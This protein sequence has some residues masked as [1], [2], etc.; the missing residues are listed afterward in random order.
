MALAAAMHGMSL[1]ANEAGATN[2]G[3]P[4]T[5]LS[6][7]IH[8]ANNNLAA[9]THYAAPTVPPNRDL[10]V[11]TGTL[12]TT[13]GRGTNQAPEYY[14]YEG[15]LPV[16]YDVPSAEKERMQARQAIRKAAATENTSASA[17]QRTDPIT[18]G[19]V[20]YLQ[21]MKAQAE[22][23]DFD[24]YFEKWADPRKPGGMQFIMEKYPQYVDRRVKQAQTDYEFAMRNQMIDSWGAQSFDDIHFKYLVDNGKIDGP[25][26]A[27]HVSLSD[28]YAPG[29]LSPWSFVDQR[30]GLYLP[31]ASAKFG[32]KPASR[33]DWQLDDTNQPM[34]SG[35]GT[36]ELAN[37]M[38]VYPGYNN[39]PNL[40]QRLRPTYFGRAS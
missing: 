38:Y 6:N 2:Y 21:S 12:P 26:L 23:A 27:K 4:D 18:E 29:L 17:V 20:D 34:S 36:Q 10:P 7:G 15:G 16:K 11:G 33:N 35:R 25:R 8:L 37:S 31:F 39:N 14:N 9:R 30:K 22:L 13:I 28:F 40:T 5:G 3:I 1:N 32:R 19:E 24:R